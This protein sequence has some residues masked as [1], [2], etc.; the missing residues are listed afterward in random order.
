MV[1]ITL[2]KYMKDRGLSDPKFAA[3]LDENLKRSKPIA[4][5]TIYR[6]RH[7]MAIPVKEIMLAIYFITGGLVDANSF[8]FINKSK[9]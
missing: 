1:N 3:L 8:Y 7:G 5:H 9:E 4:A 6:Y 2:D